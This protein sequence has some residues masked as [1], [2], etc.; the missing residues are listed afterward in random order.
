MNSEDEQK[1]NL[2]KRYTRLAI[3]SVFLL[4]LFWPLDDFFFWV[5]SGA[6]SYFTFLA[7]YYRP[8]AEQEEETLERARPTWPPSRQGTSI[9]VPPK[10]VKLIVVICGSHNGGD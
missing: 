8:R 3:V 4:A 9:K 2:V 1:L 7:F 6:T 5:F 10:N